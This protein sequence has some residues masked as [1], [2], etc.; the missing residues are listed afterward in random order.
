MNLKGSAT[1][2]L[3]VAVIILVVL[4]MSIL[5]YFFF[6]S[7]SSSFFKDN[8]GNLNAPIVKTQTSCLKTPEGEVIMRV[9][10]AGILAGGKQTGNEEYT[11]VNGETILV[12]CADVK[13]GPNPERE[14]KDCIHYNEQGKQDYQV[15]WEKKNG[16]LI[17]LKENLPWQGAQCTYSFNETGEWKDRY[18]E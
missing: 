2:I 8:K 10:E 15:V 16:Q 6:F 5:S 12:C 14:F 18:C 4:L 9:P 3:V 1:S 11:F 13:S 17:K 7:D